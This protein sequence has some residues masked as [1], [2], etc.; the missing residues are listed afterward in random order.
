VRART[1][2]LYIDKD[3]FTKALAIPTEDTIYLFLVDCDG[4]I[5]WRDTGVFSE[6]KKTAVLNTISEYEA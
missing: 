4:N 6:E 3:E 2:T 1:I 5:L